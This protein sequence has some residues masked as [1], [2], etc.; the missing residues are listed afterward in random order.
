[1]KNKSFLYSLVLLFCINS[2]L[3]F[4]L[5]NNWN[6]SMKSFFSVQQELFMLK[7][8]ITEAHLWFE[9]MI[10]GDHTINMN[11][12]IIIPLEH[13]SYERYINSLNE[14]NFI[15][16]SSTIEQLLII[17]QHLDS[18]YTLAKL[19]LSNMDFSGT[20]SVNDQLFDKEFEL[21]LFEIDRAV[22]NI[23][24]D[25][26]SEI[27]Y[28]NTNFKYIL[29]FSIIINITIFIMI[30]ITR[31]RNLAQAKQLA[32]QT[33]M[34]SLGEMLGNIAHQWRQPL[35]VISTGV[36]GMQMQ[37]KYDAL[38][39]ETFEQ[40]CNSINRNAQYL[41]DTIDD[42]S[43]YIKNESQ[44]NEFNLTDELKSFLSL[45]DIPIKNNNLEILVDVKPN[46]KICGYQ[47]ILTQC[48]INIF[49]N[50]KDAFIK[51]KQIKRRYFFVSVTFNSKN[52]VMKIKDNAGGIPEDILEKIFEPYFTTKHK[53]QGIGL[54]LHMTY[55]LI[56]NTM[57][58]QITA[59]TVKYVHNDIK[60]VGAEFIITLPVS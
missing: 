43:H 35:S 44:K 16:T 57:N 59:S 41:S 28:E 50:S 46:I 11:R 1:M 10:S 53:S 12:D 49:D 48:L 47:N 34:A 21:C 19:R 33:K 13:Q 4:L 60:C 2:T 30:I 40:T 42:F 31:R 54:G 22:M 6:S 56:T 29:F 7:N 37:K 24:K 15:G 17:D 45:V 52:L 51:N 9:E 25:F 27:S 39:D 36:T 58:G 26:E 32:E 5:H 3:L 18:L 23:S 8:N 20:G 55:N 38:S 14:K